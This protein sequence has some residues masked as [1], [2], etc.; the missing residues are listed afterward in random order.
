ME[1][2]IQEQLELKEKLKSWSRIWRTP[3]SGFWNMKSLK[4]ILDLSSSEDVTIKIR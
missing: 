2:R 1:E 3:D 4:D